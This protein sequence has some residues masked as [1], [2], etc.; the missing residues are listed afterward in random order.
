MLKLLYVNW[1]IGLRVVQCFL[2]DNIACNICVGM[3]NR[4]IMSHFTYFNIF[5]IIYYIIIIY[6]TDLH[7]KIIRHC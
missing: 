6:P 1:L 4:D 2:S 7:I 3:G 5:N